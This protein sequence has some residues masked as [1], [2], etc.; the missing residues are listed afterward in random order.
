MDLTKESPDYCMTIHLFGRG[1]SPGCAKFALKHTADDYEEE[2][3][4]D[5]AGTLRRNFYVDDMLKSVPTEEK[6]IN[7]IKGVKSIYKKGGFSLMKFVSNS[8]KMI[9]SIPD[10]DRA[11]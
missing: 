5:I 2:F 4:S 8:R 3:G 1:S 7:M 9:K 10:E 6:A 11:K